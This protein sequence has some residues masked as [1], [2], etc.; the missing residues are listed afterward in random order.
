M[1]VPRLAGG[2]FHSQYATRL[3]R[4][5]AALG[6]IMHDPNYRLPGEQIFALFLAAISLFLFYT[7]YQISEFEALS[8]PGSFPMFAT[9]VMAITALLIALKSIRLPA[10]EAHGWRAIVPGFVVFMIVMMVFYALALKPIGFLP[11]SFVF[12]T[13]STRVM[14]RGTVAR[15]ALISALSLALV[16]VVFRLIFSVLMPEGI[17]PERE[18]IA[19]LGK[20]IAD[21]TSGG[22]N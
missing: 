10:S 21:A 18:I 22:A 17:V 8:A 6:G 9:G 16:Y 11:T 4:R 5:D 1:G 2:A 14:Q 15:A 3:P 19:A 13:V 12:L 7:A 20:L